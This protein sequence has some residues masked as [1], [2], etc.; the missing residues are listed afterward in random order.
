MEN[1]QKLCSMSA[2]EIKKMQ[3][4][5]LRALLINQIYPYSPYYSRVFKEMGL[6]PYKIKGV[7]DLKHLPFTYKED[8]APTDEEPEK[9]KDFV[10]RPDEEIT[11]KYGHLAKL[12][13]YGGK[14]VVEEKIYDYKPV[15]I[16]FT[17]GRTAK[18]TP[19][20]YSKRD[21]ENIREGGYR[22]LDVFGLDEKDMF[23]NAFPYSPHLAFWQA[24]FAAEN[25]GIATLNSGGGKVMGTQNLIEAVEE[26]RATAMCFI[27]GY[28][29]YFFREA[30]RQK[31]DFSSVKT[32]LFGGERVPPGLKDKIKSLLMEMGAAE[33]LVLATYACTESRVAWGECPAETS[34]GYHI[35]PDM[36][37]IEVVDPDTGEPVGEG[38]EGEIV[39]TPLDWRGTSV[40]RY[41]T[42]DIAKGGIT[43]EPCPNCGRTVPRISANIQRKSEFKEFELTKIKGTLVNLNNFFPLMMSHPQV[44][45]WQVEIRKRNNDPFELDEIYL[46]VA[47]EE[48]CNL[49]KLKADLRQKVIR[50]TEVAPSDII[51]KPVPEILKQLGMETELK[52]KRIFDNRPTD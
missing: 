35:Y 13:P 30:A 8:V 15:H 6:D 52:E 31:R 17:T 50:D 49:E 25:S 21:L 44:V 36:E 43:Y 4:R 23:V 37:V 51:F 14:A 5:K 32:I 2:A 29:Y 42:G 47:P 40:L 45:E 7:Q 10:V 9:H 16:H 1:W 34:Y 27:P 12:S 28:A 48:G 41:R 46:Y 20:V 18:S 39:Y 19:F 38:E 24:F 26:L 11:E 33:I 22:L 3:D